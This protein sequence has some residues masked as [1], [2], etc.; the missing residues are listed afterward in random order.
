MDRYEEE[1]RGGG[2]YALPMRLI[3]ICRRR[4][5]SPTIMGGISSSTSDKSLTYDTYDKQIKHRQK[6]EGGEDRGGR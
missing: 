4:E 6:H 5:K 1:E 2:A 3:R